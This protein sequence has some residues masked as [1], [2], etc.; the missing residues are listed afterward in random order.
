[1]EKKQYK[2]IQFLSKNRNVCFSV[3]QLSLFL[4]VSERSVNRYINEINTRDSK[5]TFEIVS[6][7]GK[8]YKL[9]VNNEVYLQEYISRITEL[10]ECKNTYSYLF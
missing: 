5:K 7:Y 2:L 3:E 6:V 9:Q 8:G 1:M 4:D 10:L